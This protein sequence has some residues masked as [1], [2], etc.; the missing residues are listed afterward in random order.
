MKRDICFVTFARNEPVRL[1]VW[2]KH[3]KQLYKQEKARY[4]QLKQAAI[5]KSL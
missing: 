5:N 3:Y 4:L 2:I 1:P